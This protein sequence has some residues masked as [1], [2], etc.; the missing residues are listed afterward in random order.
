LGLPED[1]SALMTRSM[2]VSVVAASA[3]LVGLSV[4]AAQQAPAGDRKIWDGVYS[5]AQAARGKPRFETSCSR[6]HNVA[7][8]GSERGPAVKGNAFWSKW[9][10]ESLGSLY[11][12]IRDTMPQDGGAAVVS[13]EVKVDI[14]AYIMAASGIPAGKDDLKLDP[15]AL[16]GIKIAKK[17][18]VDGVYTSAQADRGK[19]TYLSGRCGGCHQL[20]LS[21]DRG[22]ALKGDDFL[23]HWENGSLNG[24]F[25]KIRE[26]M[27]P[28]GAQEVTDDAKIDIVAYLLQSNGFPAGS[29]EL[30][31]DAEALGAIDIVR[32]G[33]VASVPNFSLVQVVGCL[34][35]G[36]NNAWVLTST[37]DPVVTKEESATAT[38]L[39]SAQSKPLGNQTFRLISVASFKPDGH[40]G[41]RM[42]AR[43]LLYRDSADARLNL[44]SLQP[45]GP[46]CER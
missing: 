12:K 11:V 7:L 20:D 3:W 8:I 45:V 21:G 35:Q 28:N 41:Q 10:N 46:G 17:T 1:V 38:A 29:S 9:E 22:P 44:T 31:A 14:L 34:N 36:A 18:T 30:R 39:R 32:K 2:L 13:D 24:L 40:K 23:T 16:E 42:E 6:C 5:E 19:V 15:A 43:G 26:T 37:T 27:P 33:Q 4:I 25:D